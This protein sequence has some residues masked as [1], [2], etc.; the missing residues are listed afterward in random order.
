MR[1]FPRTGLSGEGGFNND[2]TV[3]AKHILEKN[4]VT[5][6]HHTKTKKF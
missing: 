1:G 3:L 4:S 2:S 5:G 6:V